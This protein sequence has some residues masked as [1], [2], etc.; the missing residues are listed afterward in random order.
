MLI[1]TNVAITML[2]LTGSRPTPWTFCGKNC[3]GG[4][5][6]G[7]G[8]DDDGLISYG[9]RAASFAVPQTLASCPIVH[10]E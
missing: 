1:S 7:G 6:G 10:E 2:S 9:K 4:G 8:G 3:G 5:G